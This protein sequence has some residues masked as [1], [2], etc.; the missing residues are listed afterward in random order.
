MKLKAEVL[1]VITAVLLGSVRFSPET[2]VQKTALI[3]TVW[4]HA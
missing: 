3:L 1:L 4:V 2:S